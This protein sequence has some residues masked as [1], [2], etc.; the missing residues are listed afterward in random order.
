AA[1]ATKAKSLEKGTTIYLEGKLTHRTWEDQD[2]NKKYFTEVV[3]SYFRVIKKS[4]GG[5]GDAGKKDTGYFP[6]EEPV[7]AAPKTAGHETGAV[8]ED[9]LPF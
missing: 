8:G 4:G 5:N 6:Q 7:G 1:Q 2:G 9:G 3:A